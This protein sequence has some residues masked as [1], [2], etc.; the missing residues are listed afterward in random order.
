[1]EGRTVVEKSDGTRVYYIRRRLAGKL[2][3]VSIGATTLEAAL[4]VVVARGV[5]RRSPGRRPREVA[6]VFTFRTNKERLTA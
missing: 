1:V 5:P 6:R 2:Y 4:V 3:E